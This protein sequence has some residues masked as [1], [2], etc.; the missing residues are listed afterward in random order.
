MTEGSKDELRDTPAGV[1][2]DQTVTSTQEHIL[3]TKCHLFDYYSLNNTE[4][5]FVLLKFTKVCGSCSFSFPASRTRASSDSLFETLLN[6]ETSLPHA[7]AIKDSDMCI[8]HQFHLKAFKGY[9]E[10]S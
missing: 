4:I 6:S 1:T 2:G 8:P 10:G 5:F 3:F 9:E 7:A